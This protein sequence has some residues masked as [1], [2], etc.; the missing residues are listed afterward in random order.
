MLGEEWG[1]VGWMDA[2]EEWM[3][4]GGWMMER[5]GRGGVDERREEW[6]RWSM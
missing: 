5:G 1:E 3:R 6:V 2:G 4:W